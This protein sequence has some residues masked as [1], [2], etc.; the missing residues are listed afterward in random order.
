MNVQQR[1]YGP[2]GLR[3]LP[4]GSLWEISSLGNMRTCH[5]EKTN[6]IINSKINVLRNYNTEERNDS[7]RLTGKDWRTYKERGEIT[8]QC[9]KTGS[10]KWR[11][12]GK[13]PSVK[14][15]WEYL[16]ST[17]SFFSLGSHSWFWVFN[18]AH[19]KKGGSHQDHPSELAGQKPKCFGGGGGAEGVAWL[20]CET[21]CSSA[22]YTTYS[23]QRLSWMKW[24]QHLNSHLEARGL[25]PKTLG[26]PISNHIQEEKLVM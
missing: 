18:T 16:P 6:W 21:V 3:Y 10:G 12:G 5:A 11:G 22:L 7:R 17:M 1:P 26:K 23:F 8:N 2:E 24:L 25:K 20:S 19:I 13:N 4:Y 14:W 9:K 15:G